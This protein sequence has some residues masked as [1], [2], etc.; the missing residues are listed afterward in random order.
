MSDLNKDARKKPINEDGY[1]TPTHRL[2]FQ[3]HATIFLIFSHN[4][5]NFLLGRDTKY[6]H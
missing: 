6:S 2:N 3:G 5:Q 4:E 1:K